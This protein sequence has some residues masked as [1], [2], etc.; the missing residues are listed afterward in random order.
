MD[1]RNAIQAAFQPDIQPDTPNSNT[2]LPSEPVLM[3][4]QPGYPENHHY[5]GQHQGGVLCMA[6][7]TG[8]MYLF[9]LLIHKI[10]F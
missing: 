7:I 2:Q 9:T 1:I 3:E 6:I 5:A 8:H 10:Q 4:C